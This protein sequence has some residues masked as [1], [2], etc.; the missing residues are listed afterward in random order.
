MTLQQFLNESGIVAYGALLE[1]CNALGVRAPSESDFD[2][3]V[4]VRVTS[5]QD[6]VIVLD[7]PPLLDEPPAADFD[8]IPYPFPEEAVVE[9]PK[10]KKKKKTQDE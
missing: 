5:Q 10:Q 2:A 1:R 8:E 6:G 7:P 9:Q 4:T 3:V